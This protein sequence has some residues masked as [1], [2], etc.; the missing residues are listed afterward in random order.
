MSTYGLAGFNNYQYVK[1]LPTQIDIS[2]WVLNNATYVPTVKVFIGDAL[3][4]AQIASSG[5]SPN[6]TTWTQVTL[7]I[8]NSGDIASVFSKDPTLSDPLDKFCWTAVVGCGTVY[9]TTSPVNVYFDNFFVTYT[10]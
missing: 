9:Q 10:Y 4:T 3:G 1:T 6:S 2:C 5:T 8:T 7:T